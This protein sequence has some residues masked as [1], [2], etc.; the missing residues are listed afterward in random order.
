MVFV[1]V[2]IRRFCGVDLH[3]GE[4]RYRGRKF[5]PGYGR[6]DRGR[7][8]S[9]VGYRV[10]VGD[11]ERPVV[12]QQKELALPD[13]VRTCHGGVVAVLLQSAAARRGVEG[14]ADR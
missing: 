8:D 13:P 11:A 2:V 7:G 4:G 3:S 5:Q 10:S 1:C 9:G 14:G 6:Q 12:D